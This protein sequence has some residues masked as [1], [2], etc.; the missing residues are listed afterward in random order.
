MVSDSSLW[1][2]IFQWGVCVHA[3][4]RAR[5]CVCVHVCR[6]GMLP[7]R[8]IWFPRKRCEGAQAV[9]HAQRVTNVF[10]GSPGS[11]LEPNQLLPTWCSRT[12]RGWPTAELERGQGPGSTKP[13]RGEGLARPVG[14]KEGWVTGQGLILSH[15]PTPPVKASS[16]LYPPSPR[17]SASGLGSQAG[18]HQAILGPTP[19]L[20]IFHDEHDIMSY[21]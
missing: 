21:T 15:Q 9:A 7:A 6:C 13:P 12:W 14:L 20:I 16:A 10:P 3:C 2:L 4:V 19:P 5:A 1:H 11:Q 17:P 8:A 18:R